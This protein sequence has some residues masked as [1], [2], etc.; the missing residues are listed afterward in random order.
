MRILGASSLEYLFNNTEC[1][2]FGGKHF[3]EM[4]AVI[5]VSELFYFFY[6]YFHCKSVKTKTKCQQQKTGAAE[7]GA[8]FI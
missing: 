4:L 8:T 5:L 7:K 3:I 1:E 2:N 6:I